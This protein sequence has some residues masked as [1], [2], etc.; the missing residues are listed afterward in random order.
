ML[1][2]PPTKS[3]LERLGAAQ[4]LRGL[5]ADIAPARSLV[6]ELIVARRAEAAAEDRE[7][8]TPVAVAPEAKTTGNPGASTETS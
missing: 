3:A 8:S 5:F 7:G 6:D 1:P 4:R 2:M